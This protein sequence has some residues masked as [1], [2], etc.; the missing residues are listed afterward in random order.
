[1]ASEQKASGTLNETLVAQVLSLIESTNLR[2]LRE[3]MKVTT[4][5]INKATN[6]QSATPTT[7]QLDSLFKY[8]PSIVQSEPARITRANSAVNSDSLNEDFVTA[9]QHELDS[10]SL[11][12]SHSYQVKTKWLLSPEISNSHRDLK[13]S[14][15]I[16]KFP[17]I[18]KLRDTIN[19]LPDCKGLL[20]GCI[21]NCFSPQSSRFRPHADDEP[22]I[23]QSTSICTFSLGQTRELGIFTKSHGDPQLLK[24]FPLESTSVHLMQPGS[25]A[26]TKHKVMPSRESSTDVR[27]SISFRGILTDGSAPPAE[28]S[29]SICQDTTLIFGSSIPKRIDPKRIA[30]KT[31]KLVINLSCGGG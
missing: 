3:V 29:S 17:N 8:I 5:L 13:N 28:T 22:Y 7:E 24:K 2:T 31:N 26:C 16:S 27:Y 18:C 19:K 6:P 21:V 4:N 10:L 14:E 30:G 1:M 9:L 20:N 12:Q 23:D 25:Q 15:D 11:N